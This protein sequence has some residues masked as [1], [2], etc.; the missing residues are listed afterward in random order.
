MKIVPPKIKNITL[1]LTLLGV[2]QVFSQ[3]YEMLVNNVYNYQGRSVEAFN[4]K[5]EL[6]NNFQ[7]IFEEANQTALVVDYNRKMN[8]VIYLSRVLE[9][10]LHL[11]KEDFEKRN[12]M[13]HPEK[14]DE[15]EELKEAEQEIKSSNIR[16]KNFSRELKYDIEKRDKCVEQSHV[17][18]TNLFEKVNSKEPQYNKMLAEANALS[19]VAKKA[20]QQYN[21]VIEGYNNYISSTDNSLENKYRLEEAVYLEKLDKEFGYK[22]IVSENSRLL[23]QIID[24]LI[25]KTYPETIYFDNGKIKETGLN[26]V[27][28]E[29][30]YSDEEKEVF[31]I[32]EDTYYKF[33]G[34]TGEW[35]FYNE[36]GELIET[37]VY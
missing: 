31:F 3:D 11:F 33:G 30:K 2:F 35:K 36:V 18:C 12:F 17:D 25:S 5:A 34:R 16:F 4:L 1:L 29:E 7:V 8:E 10:K 26:K 37:K 19:E 14:T 21:K 9:E 24:F 32:K 20:S 6:A 13:I 23:N 22:K 15:Y 27:L 28:V